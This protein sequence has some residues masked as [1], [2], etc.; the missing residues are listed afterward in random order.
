[1]EHLE[2]YLPFWE[3]LS[4]RHRQELESSAQIRRFPSG[5]V[6]HGGAEDCVG[7]LLVIEGRLRVYT[8]SEEGRELTLFRLFERDLCLFSA[9]CIVN[10]IRFDVTIAAERET[11]AF[12]IPAAVYKKLMAESAAVAGYTNELM[13][14]RFSEVM[15][16]M[17][18][19]LYQKM[20]V[21]LAAL[22]VEEADLADSEDLHLTHEEL[23]NHLGSAREVITRLLKYFQEE[24]VVSL[25]RGR[26]RLTDRPRLEQIAAP[27]L[28]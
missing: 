12:H 28:R 27:G 22:L 24:G 10:S 7:L 18:Q 13:A 4:E 1:M 14:S 19:I 21:R 25:A 11:C 20:D 3:K 16:L 17:D 26:I 23:A 8:T 9:S 5:E 6:L 2:D 15:W